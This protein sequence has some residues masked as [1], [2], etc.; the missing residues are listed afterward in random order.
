MDSKWADFNKISSM[1]GKELPEIVK[2]D[3]LAI[4]KEYPVLAITKPPGDDKVC[5]SD[6]KVNINI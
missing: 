1:N 6:S 2:A 4:G 3:T 5:E